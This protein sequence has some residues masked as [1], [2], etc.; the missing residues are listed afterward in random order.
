MENKDKNT[1][2]VFAEWLETLQQESWQLELI[3]SGLALYGVYS[4]KGLLVDLNFYVQQGSNQFLG[5]LYVLF[6]VGWKIF[7]I[8]LLVHVILRAL[9]IGAI[10]LR[11]VSAEINYEELNYSEY[12]TDYLKR[13]VGDYD[14]FIEKLEKICSVLFSYTFLLFLFF[15][16]IICFIIGLI[17]PITIIESL[18]YKIE[19]DLIGL[20][21]L[22]W[23]VP[24]LF[25]GLIVFIDFITIGSIKRI[26]DRT[27]SKIYMPIYRFY[28][29]ITL[30]FLYRPLI[31]NFIDS[32]YTR[33]LFYFSLP[34][35]FIII[36]GE[37][38]FSDN[39]LPHIPINT[40]RMHEGLAINN[41][42]YDDLVLDRLSYMNEDEVKAYK[43]LPAVRLSAYNIHQN[44]PSIFIK[45]DR[46]LKE[47]LDEKY[48][49]PPIYKPGW[50]FTLFTPYRKEKDPLR[51]NIKD[52]YKKQ[53]TTLT[54]QYRALRDSIKKGK[55]ATELIP[56]AEKHRD[57]LKAA[58]RNIN[59]KR[60]QAFIE[61]DKDKNVRILKAIQSLI[62]V[63][64]DSIDIT[65]QLKCYFAVHPN[66]GEKG[67]RCNFDITDF[68]EGHHDL[69]VDKKTRYRAKQDS[70]ASMR[71]VLPFI[72][73]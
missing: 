35:I 62:N 26:K 56:M 60:N 30:T 8:N 9:W 7:F 63:S 42:Y 21:S 29:T 17:L 3:I 41:H 25:L 28:S 32:K 73:Q 23:M 31:Y 27:V 2:K 70:L 44:Y 5:F 39:S 19:Q 13:K 52:E 6:E 20:I 12:F 50:R 54:N 24:Y 48:K 37:R 67:L 16:S 43:E 22:F 68:Q 58:S 46:R 47:I 15:L 71:Y 11:Y 1:K 18:G 45:F 57:S 65:D 10:G 72:K 40:F 51:E 14:D 4:S 69:I 59:V 55:V 36:T 66:H 38:L 64:I 53:H 33:R 61:F 49:I 34:Y